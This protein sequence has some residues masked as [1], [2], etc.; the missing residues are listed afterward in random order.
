MAEN[1]KLE[2]LIISTDAVVVEIV[3]E[4]RVVMTYRGYAPV[5][6]VKVDGEAANKLMYINSKSISTTLEGLKNNNSGNFT[7]I[8]VRIR[9]ESNDKFAKYIIDKTSDAVIQ[10]EEVVE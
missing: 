8:K 7:G 5:V 10:G 6:E 4:P 9:K 1:E 2:Y 3:S